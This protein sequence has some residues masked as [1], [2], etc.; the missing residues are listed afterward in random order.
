[1][2]LAG[3]VHDAGNLGDVISRIA[4]RATIAELYWVVRR[5]HIAMSNQIKSGSR[6][7]FWLG[8]AIIVLA[9]AIVLVMSS[10]PTTPRRVT[11]TVGTNGAPRLA[12]V[13]LL[14]TNMRDRTFEAM[15]ALG[16]KASLRIPPLTNDTQASNV[17]ETLKSM[18]RAGLFG[19]NQ[20][21]NPYE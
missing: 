4:L 12:G 20:R 16:I 15:G 5:S 13:P 18:S 3:E 8:A 2:A 6:W 1:M 10:K 21:P 9:G 7:F 17:L 14:T 11:L 19:T